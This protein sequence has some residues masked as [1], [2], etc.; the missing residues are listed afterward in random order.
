MKGSLLI[1]SLIF[2]FAE[3]FLTLASF[4]STLRD[5]L[6]YGLYD[7]QE[8]MLIRRGLLE[9]ELMAG[10]GKKL[11]ANKPRGV[12]SGGGFGASKGALNPDESQFFI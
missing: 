12:G 3:S 6:K 9:E 11:E 7:V 10:N 5:P 2:P 1:S 8:E 4:S